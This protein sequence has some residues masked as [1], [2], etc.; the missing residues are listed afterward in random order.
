MGFLATFAL[1]NNLL[2]G[3][4]DGFIRHIQF[5]SELFVHRTLSRGAEYHSLA[6][7]LSVVGE[8]GM[9]LLQ[10]FGPLM[11]AAA[12][13]GIV[14]AV[15]KRAWVSLSLLSFVAGYYCLTVVLTGEVFTRWLIGV[16]LIL[17][18]FVGQACAA[19]LA[20]SGV[21]RTV[22]AILLTL[23]LSTQ[24]ALAVNLNYTLLRDSRVAMENW[25]RTHVPRG[26]RVESQIQV[27]YLPRLADWVTYEIVGNR[28]DAIDYALEAAAF[29]AASLRQRDPDYILMLE[30]SRLTG[31][32]TQQTDP[33]IID[34]FL[35][36][37]AGMLGYREVAAFDTPNFLPFPQVTAAGVSLRTVLLMRDTNSETAQA[38]GYPME[39]KHPALL[40]LDR[41]SQTTVSKGID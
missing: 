12:A 24:A 22:G 38:E 3:G 40:P 25:M 31:D 41:A 21:S 7:Q 2:F 11:L 23:G 17:T 8:S 14:Q 19:L 10:M 13:I 9:L 30:N 15:R 26:V 1:V 18:L 5:S 33:R 16:A 34:Y 27:R 4:L 37:K 20:G 36:L 29:D 6:H 35:K 39:S 28:Y 32:P